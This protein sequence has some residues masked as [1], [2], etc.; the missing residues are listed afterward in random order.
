MAEAICD[1][2]P[3]Y[4]LHQAACLDWL[5]TLF[6]GIW[7]PQAVANE[8]REGA[9]RGYP[10]PRLADLPWVQIKD[11]TTIPA[12]WLALDLGPGE[13]AAMALAQ[14]FPEHRLVL[15]DGLARKVAARADLEVW[16]TLRIVLEAKERGLI[17][18]VAPFLDRL[19][20][21]GMWASSELLRE[22]L[23]LAGEAPQ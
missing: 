2:S 18:T 8:L 9:A 15:D 6:G 17:A 11:P 10:V 19:V 22:V 21:A 4:Y 3:L 20:A 23:I 14:E 5:E 12:D 7:V 16:G 1:T 13:L